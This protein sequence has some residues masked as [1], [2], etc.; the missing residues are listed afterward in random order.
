MLGDTDVV[1]NVAVKDLNRAKAFYRDILGLTPH[2]GEG[3]ALA[4]FRSGISLLNVY[5]SDYAGTNQA[6]A[7]TWQVDSVDDA[8]AALKEKGVRFEHYDMPG[9]T[10]DG[11]IY[12]AGD[13]RIAWFKDPDGNILNLVG[14]AP[15]AG[16]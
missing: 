13:Y 9:L 7:L 5:R 3:D 4:V 14:P 12:D 15:Q 1:A 10:R 16:A 2:G 6:T 8:V 11:D